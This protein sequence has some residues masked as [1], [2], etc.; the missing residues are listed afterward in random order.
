MK[1]N[2]LF[3]T[4]DQHRFDAYGFTGQWGKLHTPTI[5]RLR[6]EGV[7]YP[8]AVATCPICVP[9]RFVWCHG[10]QPSQG[11]VRLMRNAADWPMFPSLPGVLQEQGYHTSLVGKLHSFHGDYG[12]EE[13]KANTHARGF[14]D[15]HE[16]GGRSLS[17]G[18]ECNYTRYLREQGLLDAYRSDLKDRN[19]NLCWNEPYRPSVV[20]YEHHMDVYIRKHAVEWIETYDNESPFFLHVSLCGPHFP[21]DPPEG[22]FGRNR[23][24][25]MPPPGGVEDEKEIQYWQEIRA[26]YSDLIEMVD[27]EMGLVLDA[28]ERKGFLDN[29]L[30][31][32]C[33]DHGDLMGDKQVW[34]KGKPEDGSVRTPW[35]IRLPDTLPAGEQRSGLVESVDI[36]ATLMEAAGIHSDVNSVLPTSPSRSW[37]QNAMNGASPAPREVA[38]AEGGDWRMVATEDWKYIFTPHDG[39]ERLHDRRADPTDAYDLSKECSQQERLG[40]FRAHLLQRIATSC[41]APHAPDTPVNKEHNVRRQRLRKEATPWPKVPVTDW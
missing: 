33:S 36:A 35:F 28:L 26:A 16:V 24:Q 38:Y 7:T 11:N 23:P 4:N 29:T 9:N 31:V 27:H 10:L 17:Y 2:I 40:R 41:V 15:V 37:W 5:D 14:R 3:L 20:P 32:H 18:F 6:S 1:P 13:H 19:A 34:N 21:I 25:D 30:I 22:W 12:S 8:N 39:S